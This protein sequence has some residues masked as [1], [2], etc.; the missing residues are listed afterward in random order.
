MPW[1]GV[2]SAGGELTAVGREAPL[3]TAVWVGRLAVGMLWVGI[4][5]SASMGLEAA[6]G[7]V[8][9]A[10]AESEQH[11]S[12]SPIEIICRIN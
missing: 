9:N 8:S 3:F 2:G 7:V 4:V 10:Q 12:K 11:R 6:S 5:L 1:I